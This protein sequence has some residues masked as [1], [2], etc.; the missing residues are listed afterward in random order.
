M[1]SICLAARAPSLTG[2]DC[3]SVWET[4][5]S[6]HQEEVHEDSGTWTKAVILRAGCRVLNASSFD[7]NTPKGVGCVY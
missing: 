6:G 3:G 1:T 2:R 7:Q 5:R 4:E